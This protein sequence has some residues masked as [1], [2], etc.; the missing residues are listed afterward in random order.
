MHVEAYNINESPK[1]EI[2][3]CTFRNSDVGI[4]AKNSGTKVF[5]RNSN[6]INNNVGVQIS[7]S[8]FVAVMLNSTFSENGTDIDSHIASE[9]WTSLGLNFIPYLGDAK[10]LLEAFY[11]KDLLTDEDLQ[12]WERGVSLFCLSEIR[13]VNKGKNAIKA[14]KLADEEKALELYFKVGEDGEKIVPLLEKYGDELIEKYK[15]NEDEVA[16]ALKE[17]G[18]EAAKLI[19]NHGKESIDLIAQYGHD[20]IGGFNYADGLVKTKYV[21]SQSFVQDGLTLLR[22]PPFN[23][24]KTDFT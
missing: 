2:S 21:T 14:L 16:F 18:D 22:N 1:V 15:I 3:D 12:L 9:F 11:G 23:K 10:G 8:A 20:A 24:L 4:Y 13:S 7:K 19:V 17:F 5:V 6:F